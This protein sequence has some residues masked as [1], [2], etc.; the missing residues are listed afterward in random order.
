MKTTAKAIALGI[1]KALSV[2]VGIILLLW[3]LFEIQALIL[4]IGLALVVSLIGRPVVLFLKKRLKFRNTFASVLTLLI[5]IGLFSLLLSIF[6]PILIEQGKHISQIDFEQVK[7]DL[8][9]LNIQASDYL[10]V[11]HFQLVEAVKRT[12]YV[13]EFDREII[14]SFID[15]FFG[16]IAQTLVGIFSVLFISF[17]LLKDENLIARCVLVFANSGDEEKFK[18]ILIKIKELLSRYFIGLLLQI[19]LLALFYSVLL[20]Y[21][22]VNDAV[23]VAL[24]CAFLNIVPYLG[25]IIAWILMLLVVVSNNL[26]ADFS[27][28]LLP[29]LLLVSAGYAI[30]QIFDNF[31]SQPV[32]F[33]HSVR[34][35]PLEIFIVILTGGYLFGI[36]GMILAVPTYTAL[37]VIAKEFLSEYKIVKR[38]TRN[39]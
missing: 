21:L 33:G 29:L 2:L 38:L 3:F 23:A 20:L 14:P 17:F 32:I 28:G 11:D 37:K 1:L 6:V 7:R 22:D 16:N 34:S 12:T 35:H 10:G 26:G 19:F 9:E 4:Y 5:I 15:I 25:P 8:N 13:Q 18:R 36:P 27:S 39:L 24:I 31:I 30:A